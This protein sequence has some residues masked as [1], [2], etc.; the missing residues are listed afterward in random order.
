M[1]EAQHS[2]DLGVNGFGQLPIPVF[3]EIDDL[4][5]SELI[6]VRSICHS[7]FSFYFVSLLV[8]PKTRKAQPIKMDRLGRVVV[9]GGMD[10]FLKKNRI[11]DI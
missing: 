11:S 4:V 5:V 7:C 10:M 6:A 1:S 2:P 8:S 3:G 9:C